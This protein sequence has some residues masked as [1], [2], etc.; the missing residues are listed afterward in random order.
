MAL[1]LYRSIFLQI[2]Y[3]IVLWAGLTAALRR[4]NSQWSGTRSMAL[5]RFPSCAELSLT[6]SSLTGRNLVVLYSQF[7]LLHFTL[8]LTQTPRPETK[9][10]HPPRLPRSQAHQVGTQ[11]GRDVPGGGDDGPSHGE[12]AGLCFSG[13]QALSHDS[14]SLSWSGPRTLQVQTIKMTFYFHTFI[15]IFTATF[16]K[17]LLEKLVLTGVMR[18]HPWQS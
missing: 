1:Y 3:L 7:N 4:K 13:W 11:C 5:S 10:E 14:R 2:Y 18:K 8:N 9:W 12:V 15:F 16:G 17:P 6:Q